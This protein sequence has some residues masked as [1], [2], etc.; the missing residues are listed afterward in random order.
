MAAFL[1]KESAWRLECPH[2]PSEKPKSELSEHLRVR[3]EEK[4]ASLSPACRFLFYSV[5]EFSNFCKG[6][7]RVPLLVGSL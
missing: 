5:L 2:V 3:M 6:L 7:T 1:A 4:A